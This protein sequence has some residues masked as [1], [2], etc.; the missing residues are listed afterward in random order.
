MK[1]QVYIQQHF[2]RG[3]V[4]VILIVARESSFVLLV[5][6]SFA[7]EK[8]DRQ[9]LFEL[10]QNFALGAI[11]FATGCKERYPGEAD[12]SACCRD[13]PKPHGSLTGADHQAKVKTRLR[14]CSSVQVLEFG[15]SRIPF[16]RCN[17]A[18]VRR[19]LVEPPCVLLSALSQSDHGA[20]EIRLAH[21][22]PDT[23]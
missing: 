4:L 6:V 9:I 18:T 5:G 13:R 7:G 21:R 19:D 2:R 17:W 8:R 15:V 14:R 20:V 23:L 10:H 22:D 16:D 11:E 3:N 12:D 1:Q